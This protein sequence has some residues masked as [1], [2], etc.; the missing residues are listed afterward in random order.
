MVPTGRLI[1][2][3]ALGAPLALL[4]A[5]AR[6]DL[7]IVAPAWLALCIVAWLLDA[8]LAPKPQAGALV[9]ETPQAVAVGEAAEMIARVSPGARGA[10]RSARVA[11]EVDSRLSLNGRIDDDLHVEGEGLHGAIAIRPLRR[12]VARVGRGWFGW[13]GPFGLARLQ[14]KVRVDRSISV[15]PSI[16]AVKEE[17]AKLFARDA[18][19]G[20]RLQAR[21]GEGSEF[22]SLVRF[23]PGLD[24]RTIDWKQSARHT[25]LLA[26]QYQTER[27]NRIVLAIDSGRLMS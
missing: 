3:M 16:R 24:R 11:L 1:V 23:L 12:G 4:V 18:Q 2:L 8:M 17:G 9:I 25:D 21:L 14:R 26:K 6:S 10:A 15:V 13:T 22:E 20:Q 27:D 5:F 19:I 7:W